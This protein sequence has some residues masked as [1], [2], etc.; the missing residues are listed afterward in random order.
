MILTSSAI[1]MASTSVSAE[2]E[3]FQATEDCCTA[4]GNFRDK[5]GDFNIAKFESFIFPP[6]FFKKCSDPPATSAPAP[7]PAPAPATAAD[8]VASDIEV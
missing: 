4:I 2:D 8:Q 6:L 1:A 7:T 5:C 3:E